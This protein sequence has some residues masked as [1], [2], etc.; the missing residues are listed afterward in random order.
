MY[1]VA[2]VGN[3]PSDLIPNLSE[4]QSEIDCWIG[5][6]RGALSIIKNNIPLDYA[7]GDFDSVTSSELETIEGYAKSIELFPIEKDQTDLELALSI[8]FSLNVTRIYF[9]G[10]TGGRMDH[11]LINIQLLNQIINQG[12][13]G[14]IID[15]HNHLELF[16]P[17]TYTVT[18]DS[19][20]P[21][22]SF[23]PITREVIGLSLEGFYY[24]L[25]KARIMMGST[26]S[27]SNKLIR[28]NGTFSFEDGIVLVVRSRD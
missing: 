28:N 14:Y 25:K 9:F 27:I 20:Y 4:F 16:Y 18:F 11:T 19:L 21:T 3:G 8:A 17:G 22:I 2:I 10:V 13:Q 1:T 7:V 23:I 15:K 6:D 26:L 24:P 5:A 12:I